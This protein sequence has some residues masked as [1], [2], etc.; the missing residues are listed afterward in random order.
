MGKITLTKTPIDGL[1]IVEPQIFGDARGYFTE[2]YNWRDFAALNLTM[3]FVQ[4]N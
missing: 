3:D 4:D 2:T 1:L